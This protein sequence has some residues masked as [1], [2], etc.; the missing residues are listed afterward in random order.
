MSIQNYN[1]EKHRTFDKGYLNRDIQESF[2]MA[3]AKICLRLEGEYQLSG[4]LFLVGKG[5]SG[6]ALGTICG[7][8]YPSIMRYIPWEHDD[9]HEVLATYPPEKIVFIDDFIF[10]GSTINAVLADICFANAIVIGA[11]KDWKHA[12]DYK[13]H[14]L[15]G[16]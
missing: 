4:G 13:L 8:L 1:W 7:F 5:Q 10:K 3:A 9:N 11:N 15:T 14:V 2:A 6:M 12:E 16:S